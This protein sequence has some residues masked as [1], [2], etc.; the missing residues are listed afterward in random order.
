MKA[1]CVCLT[2]LLEHHMHC[3]CMCMC[4]CMSM[5]M[6]TCTACVRP[7][8]SSAAG[9]SDLPRWKRV[10]L[11]VARSEERASMWAAGKLP[12]YQVCIFPP[13]PT[14]RG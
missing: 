6:S 9:A 1:A 2:C 4:M 8:S 13:S 10:R 5:C 3:M 14:C 7:A 12:E 11:V